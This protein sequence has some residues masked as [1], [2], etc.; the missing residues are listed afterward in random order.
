MRTRRSHPDG[1]RKEVS[2]KKP[3]DRNKERKPD[4]S[5]Q[6]PTKNLEEKTK[7]PTE[8]TDSV[9][10]A[11]LSLRKLRSEQGRAKGSRR[12]RIARQEGV[13]AMKKKIPK[14]GR[15]LHE[16]T[17]AEEQ[18]H[19]TTR[20]GNSGRKPRPLTAERHPRKRSKRR[21]RHPKRTRTKRRTPPERTVENRV[22]E[23]VK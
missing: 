16:W 18:G 10:R 7:D 8:A 21:K 1:E 3:R 19:K 12:R 14:Q 22:R 5:T 4:S 9:Q 2:R 11:T 17:R 13:V 20:E 23:R 6:R 15:E